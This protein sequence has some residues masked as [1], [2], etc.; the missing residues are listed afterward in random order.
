MSG[1][2]F[3][4]WF[5]IKKEFCH[6]KTLKKCRENVAS[7]QELKDM[8]ESGNYKDRIIKNFYYSKNISGTNS[9]WYQRKEH[10]KSAIE[11]NDFPTTF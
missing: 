11:Q 7:I 1:S 3:G 8:L 4:Y 9:N 2:I 6:K 10:L 5:C